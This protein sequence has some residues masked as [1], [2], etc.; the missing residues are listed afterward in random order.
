M[1][2]MVL[3]N[4]RSPIGRLAAEHESETDVDESEIKVVIQMNHLQAAF[5]IW[6]AGLAISAVALAVEWWYFFRSQR[7]LNRVRYFDRNRA[8]EYGCRVD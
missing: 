4:M 6:A 1:G 3:W 7:Q 5:Y 8:L 2:F